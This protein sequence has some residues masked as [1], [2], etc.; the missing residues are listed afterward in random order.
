MCDLSRETFFYGH[1]WEYLRKTL[2]SAP[3]ALSRNKL[4]YQ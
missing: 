3:E 1:P 2:E 4:K